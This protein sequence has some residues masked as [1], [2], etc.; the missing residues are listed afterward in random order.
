MEV[1]AVGACVFYPT[2]PTPSKKTPRE[3][4]GGGTPRMPRM[5]EKTRKHLRR[6]VGRRD[7]VDHEV[8]AVHHAFRRVYQ[9]RGLLHLG[10]EDIHVRR[11]K[12]LG[13]LGL[14]QHGRTRHGI[15]RQ[16]VG[17]TVGLHWK[18]R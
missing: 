15:A 4:E 9:C 7:V 1:E 6:E 2:E 5:Q 14:A 13:R 10:H 8:D 17:G 18:E 3:R 16:F 11:S 12:A